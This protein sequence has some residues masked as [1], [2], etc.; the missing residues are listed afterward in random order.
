MKWPGDIYLPEPEQGQ[1]VTEAGNLGWG[2]LASIWPAHLLFRARRPDL[3]PLTQL[4][5]LPNSEDKPQPFQSHPLHLG[6]SGG[7]QVQ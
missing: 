5:Q 3:C 4:G 6:H 2:S 1:G 7:P